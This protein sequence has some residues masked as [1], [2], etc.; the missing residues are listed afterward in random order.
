LI[1]MIT[2]E[3]ANRNPPEIPAN[4]LPSKKRNTGINYHLGLSY[5]NAGRTEEAKARLRAALEQAKGES[6]ISDARG[7]LAKLG[8]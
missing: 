7:A 8:G 5:Q 3:Y 6:W 1:P 4:F 2:V